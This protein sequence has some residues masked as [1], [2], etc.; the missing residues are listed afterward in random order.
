MNAVAQRPEVNGKFGATFIFSLLVHG[1]LLFGIGFEYVKSKPD[2]T[3]LDVT[4]VT[5]ANNNAPDKA[6][7]L[8][9]ANNQ[10]PQ[11]P[12]TPINKD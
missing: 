3:T 12:K 10:G 6:D 7:F 1:M 8:A 2:L 4:L 11:N 5:V 9:Q